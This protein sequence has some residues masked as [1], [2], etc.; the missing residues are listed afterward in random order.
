MHDAVWMDKVHKL[1]ELHKQGGDLN[2]KG[3]VGR[4]PLHKAVD[5]HGGTKC[6]EYLLKHGADIDPRDKHGATPL[7][8]AMRGGVFKIATILLEY[9]AD[10]HARD[11]D[12]QTPFHWGVEG[13][14]NLSITRLLLQHGADVHATDIRGET[15]LHRAAVHNSNLEMLQTLLDNGAD[16]N[17][18]DNLSNTPL[19]LALASPYFLSVGEEIDQKE[20]RE[21]EWMRESFRLKNTFGRCQGPFPFPY[22]NLRVI[23][24]LVEHGADIHAENHAGKTP[25]DIAKSKCPDPDVLKYLEQKASLDAKQ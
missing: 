16:I 21:K 25:L 10:V 15:P 1:E 19:L 3:A 14:Y 6:A 5:N 7:H 12:E 2:T 13:Y 4:T 8:Y 11:K 18:R 20:Q 22:I 17:A 24:F 23:E 9:Q